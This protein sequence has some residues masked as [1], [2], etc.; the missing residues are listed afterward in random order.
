M[1]TSYKFICRDQPIL[2]H[3]R[4]VTHNVIFCFGFVERLKE[5]LMGMW[6]VTTPTL[7][8]HFIAVKIFNLTKQSAL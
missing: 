7:G 3:A 6:E 8:Y 1:I 2:Q 5:W 4:T